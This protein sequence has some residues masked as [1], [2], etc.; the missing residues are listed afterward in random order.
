MH[1]LGMCR[2]DKRKYTNW[3]STTQPPLSLKLSASTSIGVSEVLHE[4][5]IFSNVTDFSLSGKKGEIKLT[6]LIISFRQIREV[7]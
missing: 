3:G 7:N 5:I 1:F 6:Q 4:T 2:F